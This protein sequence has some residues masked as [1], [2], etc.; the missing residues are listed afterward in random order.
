LS[1]VPNDLKEKTLKR[2]LEVHGLVVYVEMVDNFAFAHF[3]SSQE[4]KNALNVFA[5]IKVSMAMSPSSF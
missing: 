4:A 5:N 1:N 3:E 2:M